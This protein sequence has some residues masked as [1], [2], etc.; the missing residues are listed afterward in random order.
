DASLVTSGSG[1]GGFGFRLRLL[2]LRLAGLRARDGCVSRLVAGLRSGRGSVSRLVRGFRGDSGGRFAD[3]ERRHLTHAELALEPVHE[4]IR[5]A[6]AHPRSVELRERCPHLADDIRVAGVV[7]ARR[8][9]HIAIRDGREVRV[10]EIVEGERACEVAAE[11]L[12]PLLVVARN[13]RDLTLA[14][15][16]RSRVGA[17]RGDLRGQVLPLEDEDDGQ[18]AFIDRALETLP[19]GVLRFNELVAVTQILVDASR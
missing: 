17:P 8:V 18:M 9:G 10:P 12:A 2:R 16:I 7:L 5:I 19:I 14:V 4:L 1:R 6:K 11:S 15:L 3:L 13:L